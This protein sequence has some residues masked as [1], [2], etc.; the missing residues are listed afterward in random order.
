MNT[1]YL[2]L[3]VS[4]EVAKSNALARGDLVEALTQRGLPA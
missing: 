4:V 1:T 2:T 3:D